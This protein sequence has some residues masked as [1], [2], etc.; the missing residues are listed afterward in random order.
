M[1]D[2]INNL[3][4]P[5]SM[6][7]A[8]ALISACSLAPERR[9]PAAIET[10][11]A[12]YDSR[13]GGMDV[14]PQPVARW[15]NQYQDPQLN[16]LVRSAL[17]GNL[18]LALA[19]ARLREAEA[20]YR[21]ARGGLWPG[22]EASVDGSHQDR[23][24]D[25]GI[26]AQFGGLPGA[27]QRPERIE[28]QSYSAA[29]TVAW[30]V[31]LWRRIADGSSAAAA[32]TRASALEVTAARQALISNLVREYFTWVAL[33]EQRL[34]TESLLRFLAERL[35]NADER[36]SRGLIDS[37][38]LYSVRQQYFSTQA[39]RPR[40]LAAAEASRN[41]LA[42]LTGQYAQSL[43]LN[44]L[45]RPVITEFAPQ[46]G[47]PSE[48]LNRRPDVAAAAE[49]LEAARLQMGVA[50]ANRLPMVRLSGTLGTEGTDPGDLFDPDQWFSTLIAQIMAPLFQGGRLAA[51]SDAAR[52]RYEQAGLQYARQFMQAVADVQTALAQ[53]RSTVER[54]DLLENQ[55]LDA[56]RSVRIEQERFA[57][58]LGA[59]ARYL[60]ARRSALVSQ[61]D[62]SNT[63]RDLGLAQVDLYLALGGDW[64]EAD[65]Q[66]GHAIFS[67]PDDDYPDPELKELSN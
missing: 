2:F 35:A 19:S 24:A 30:E 27:G 62:F 15:W 8:V 23:P 40:L 21:A 50:R 34:L 20:N 6:L 36:Y 44:S 46:A 49:S 63:R 48:L 59:Y 64:I 41:R 47:V 54:L 31:D 28:F 61:I 26:T 53:Y 57:E 55:L 14:S 67:I 43:T 25:S 52:A 33:D 42:I 56:R 51:E 66:A 39:Q 5:V 3:R 58:G 29:A 1:P 60:D 32:R 65:Q 18:D 10:A 45:Q 38:E 16:T 22:V 7:L 17:D 4:F 12:S 9:A 37:F 13:A 11:P